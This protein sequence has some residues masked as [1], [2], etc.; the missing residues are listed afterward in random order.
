MS[1]DSKYRAVEEVEGENAAPIVLDPKTEL[2]PRA[3]A[4]TAR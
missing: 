2:E 4:G 1:S 3:G